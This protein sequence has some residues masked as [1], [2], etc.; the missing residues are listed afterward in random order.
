MK[1]RI[2]QRITRLFAI[3]TCTCTLAFSPAFADMPEPTGVPLAKDLQSDAQ[4]A[5]KKGG[6]VLVLFE[7]EHCGYCRRVL[8]EF[9]IP[10][11]RNPEY[12]AKLVMRKVDNAGYASLKDFNGTRAAHTDFSR[13]HHVRMVP[14]VMLFDTQGNRLTS[15]LVGLSTADYYGYYL[16]QAIDEALEKSKNAGS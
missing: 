14:T 12:Q 8:N 1:Q 13:R 10:M 9:L 6:V 4:L 3:V 2:I 5:R 7:N 16:D 15:P 11:S